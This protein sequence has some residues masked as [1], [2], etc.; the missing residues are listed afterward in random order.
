MCNMQTV[1]TTTHFQQILFITRTE[2]SSEATTSEPVT[3]VAIDDASA[4][5]GASASENVAQRALADRQAEEFAE[6]ETQPLG[7][8]CLGVVQVDRD[9]LPA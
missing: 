4:S 9:V 2:V 7:P 1:I 3:S 5:S 8:Y 6:H